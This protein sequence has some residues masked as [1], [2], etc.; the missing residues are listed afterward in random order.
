MTPGPYPTVW[1]CPLCGQPCEDDYT[2]QSWTGIH[3]AC[4]DQAGVLL[5][6]PHVRERWLAWPVHAP[7]LKLADLEAWAQAGPG[8]TT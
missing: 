4:G 7:L 3:R 5:Q 2:F 1:R 8:R 6:I